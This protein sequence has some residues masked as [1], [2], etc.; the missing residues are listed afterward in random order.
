MCFPIKTSEPFTEVDHRIAEIITGFQL[1]SARWQQ[2]EE[3]SM[4]TGD[5][6]EERPVAFPASCSYLGSGQTWLW[7]VAAQDGQQNQHFTK[8]QNQPHCWAENH[9]HHSPSA[10]PRPQRALLQTECLD[11]VKSKLFFFFF[12]LQLNKLERKIGFPRWKIS[13]GKC[14]S[15]VFFLIMT[16]VTLTPQ[17]ILA[18]PQDPN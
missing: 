16:V 1:S 6:R 14:W 2:A 12:L 13:H 5:H 7:A 15:P 17:I 8:W 10:A 11:N 18:M 9:L 3:Q 4:R